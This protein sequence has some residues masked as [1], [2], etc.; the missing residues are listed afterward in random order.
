[1]TLTDAQVKGFQEL[2]KKK[3]G[4]ELTREQALDQGIRLVQLMRAVY[5]PMPK[6][7]DDDGDSRR[8]RRRLPGSARS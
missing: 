6:S 8:L 5:K 1:M 2:Y 7:K 3:F 4:V